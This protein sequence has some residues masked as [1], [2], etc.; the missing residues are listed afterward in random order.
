MK[1][2]ILNPNQIKRYNWGHQLFRNEIGRQCDYALFYGSGFPNFDPK[3]TVPQIIKKYC[4]EKPNVIMTYGWRYS[5]DFEG[6]G[7]INDIAKVNITVDYV[8]PHGFPKQNKMFKKNKYDL[9]FA[10]TQRALTLQKE[11]NVCDKIRLL[12]FSVD[13]TIYKNL[14]LPTENFVLASYSTRSDV[15]PNRGKVRRIVKSMGYRLATKQIIHD[16]YVKAINRARIVLTSNNIFNSLSMRYT[17]VLACGGF[18]LVNKP[19]DLDLLGFKDGVHLVIY[20]DMNDLKNKVKYYM[21]PKNNK[22]RKKIANQG[23]KFVRSNHS[24]KKRA[25]EFYDIIKDELSI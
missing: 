9:V 5:K 7:D 8:R 2:L 11:N 15:Y 13:T 10:I 16:R 14:N 18:L 12:P 24:C 20:K 21:N 23:M 3:L 17:E 4:V 19:D 1:I 25:L 6:L 22:E